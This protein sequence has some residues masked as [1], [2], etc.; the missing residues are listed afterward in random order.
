MRTSSLIIGIALLSA[1]QSV[2]LLVALSTV[3]YQAIQIRRTI[4]SDRKL[5]CNSSVPEEYL[6]NTIK[7]PAVGT[8]GPARRKIK[9]RGVMREYLYYYE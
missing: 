4:L 6:C 9:P 7:T 8:T 1:V 3:R 2:V 5:I